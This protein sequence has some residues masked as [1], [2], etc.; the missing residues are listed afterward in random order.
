MDKFRGKVFKMRERGGISFNSYFYR[1][2]L[3]LYLS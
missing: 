3:S 1:E 2:D